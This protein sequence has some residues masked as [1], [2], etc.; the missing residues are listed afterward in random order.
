MSGLPSRKAIAH[1][2]AALKHAFSAAMEA[3]KL[4]HILSIV[5]VSDP[6]RGSSVEINEDWH[7]RA[8]IFDRKVKRIKEDLAEV[9]GNFSSYATEMGHPLKQ[10]HGL[11]QRPSDKNFK[12]GDDQSVYIIGRMIKAAISKIPDRINR[13]TSNSFEPLSLK[14]S[15]PEEKMPPALIAQQQQLSQLQGEYRDT[16]EKSQETL[17]DIDTALAYF[18]E[19]GGWDIKKYFPKVQER[20][21]QGRGLGQ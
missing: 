9:I 5:F 16:M 10:L 19:L 12:M 20:F 1:M 3:E 2:D 21:L 15:R 18:R 6:E 14:Y 11:E 17:N 4:Q 7:E 8:T 13:A